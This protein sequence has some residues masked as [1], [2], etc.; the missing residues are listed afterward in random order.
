MRPEKG[1]WDV[2]VFINSSTGRED[3]LT[4]ASLVIT[5]GS[6]LSVTFALSPFE[7]KLRLSPYNQKI[8]RRW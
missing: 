6:H 5:M 4:Y 1:H 8:S 3:P 7:S 2:Y